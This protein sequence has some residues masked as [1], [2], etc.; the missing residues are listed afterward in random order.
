MLHHSVA[1]KPNNQCNAD[2]ANKIYQRKK[3]GIIKDR[4]D[5]CFAMLVIDLSKAPQGLFFRIED[6]HSLRSRNVLLKKSK[7]ARNARTHHIKAAPRA[8]AKPGSRDKQQ[9]HG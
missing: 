6:L 3:D 9:R 4:V 1:A 2:R 7:D 5:V 8:F